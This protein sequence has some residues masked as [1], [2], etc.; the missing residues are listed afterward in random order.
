VEGSPGATLAPRAHLGRQ[1]ALEI[2]VKQREREGSG[3][4][5]AFAIL[6]RRA[7]ILGLSALLVA[8]A[9]LVFSLL[10]EKKY[11]ASASL[12][13]RQQQQVIGDQATFE[14]SD[15]QR[16]LETNL[17]LLQL[18]AVAAQAAERIGG[19]VTES[20][21]D[22]AIE[23]E[24]TEDSDVISVEATDP[25][26]DQAAK[27]ANGFAEA[28]VIFRQRADR[29]KVEDAQDRVEQLLQSSK[30]SPERRSSLEAR[31]DELQTVADLQTGGVELVEPAR[32][33]SSPSSPKLERNSLIGAFGGLLLGIAL[34]LLLE[35]VDRGI[36]R[37]EELQEIFDVPLIGTI[38]ESSLIRNG[39]PGQ[40]VDW[41]STE[42]FRM[43][44]ASLFL[45][46][47]GRELQSVLVTSAGPEDG[48][49]TVALGLALAAAEPG[50]KVLLVEADLRRPSL[51]P[52]LDLKA[53][54]GLS[55]LLRGRA[56]QLAN[57]TQTVAMKDPASDSPPIAIDVLVAGPHPPNAAELMESE[58]MTK[59]L[60][61]AERD[62]DLVV[63]DTP[64]A[65]LI[66][67][68]IPLFR[69]VSGIILVSR[70]QE[71]R[72]D[73]IARFKAQLDTV[74]PEIL[75]VVANRVPRA[76]GYYAYEYYGEAEPAGS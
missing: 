34:V 74:H 49:T 14:V 7:W 56:S 35:Q 69:Q 2:I 13:V 8:G 68:P 52:L 11:T 71:S 26:P 70:L 54:R 40:P 64:P 1:A 53:R 39:G 12:L 63:I 65:G 29:E 32:S 42:A 30:L 47:A 17:R 38:P 16:E 61:A 75:G 5:E 31:A 55:T 62:Y 67:D 15:P 72:R 57:F 24:A 44:R 4:L 22:S 58:A 59:L 46:E 20:E 18:D 43:L 21:V 76:A 51:A 3:L 37:P 10:A 60:K 27:I 73:T 6:R 23:I 28:F 50:Q 36:R 48:K 41:Q 19:D 9:A 66:S 33:P 25:D 45:S